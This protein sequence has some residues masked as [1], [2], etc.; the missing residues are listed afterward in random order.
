MTSLTIYITI[1]MINTICRLASLSPTHT[2][3]AITHMHLLIT[4]PLQLSLSEEALIVTITGGQQV[5][6]VVRMKEKLPIFADTK[7]STAASNN[8]IIRER[9]ST[10]SG[11]HT[12]LRREANQW[13]VTPIMAGR[14]L[15]TII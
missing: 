4:P 15:C 14:C 12:R 1:I 2:T 6:W 11:D 7:A 10:S 13:R 9:P 5:Q 3:L 8:I